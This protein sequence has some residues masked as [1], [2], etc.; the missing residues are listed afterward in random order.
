LKRLC[1]WSK[2]HFKSVLTTNVSMMAASSESGGS[3][4][5]KRIDSDALASVFQQLADED[6]SGGPWGAE[7][8]RSFGYEVRQ[9]SFAGKRP[10][11]RAGITTL[12][13]S[14]VKK[15]WLE[16]KTGRHAAWSPTSE[17]LIE[18]RKMLPEWVTEAQELI[19][20]FGEFLM[21]ED[22]WNQM[23]RLALASPV[24]E[25]CFNKV[26]LPWL[27]HDSFWLLKPNDPD[28]RSVNRRGELLRKSPAEGFDD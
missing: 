15:G 4:G 25:S 3:S 10:A 14:W 17:G 5:T 12:C 20:S 11:V 1:R 27:Q 7:Q 13:E 23:L 2:R 18:F 8:L 6:P 24:Q 16:A 28:G 22:D 26:F 21:S 9:Q 19:D